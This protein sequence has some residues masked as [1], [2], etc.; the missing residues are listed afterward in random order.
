MASEKQIEANRRNAQLSTGPTTPEG[1]AAVSQNAFKHGLYSDRVLFAQG[2]RREFLDRIHA[3]FIAEFQPQTMLEDTLVAKM[4][5]AVYKRTGFEEQE[6]DRE[7]AIL[8]RNFQPSLTLI[9]RRQASLDR[10]FYQAL[11]TLRQLQKERRQAQLAQSDPRPAQAKPADP[12]PAEPMAA[13][14]P[15]S[16]PKRE[17]RDAPPEAPP[18]TNCVLLVRPPEFL[19]TS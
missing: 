11:K 14:Q 3:D 1:K 15:E 17:P 12:K 9:W 5:V 19:P 4:A 7:D 16:A 10:E 2:Q 18:F 6:A 13:A 8:E